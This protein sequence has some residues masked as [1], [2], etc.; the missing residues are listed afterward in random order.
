MNRIFFFIALASLFTTACEKQD[1]T[2]EQAVSSDLELV[3]SDST[4]QLTG[5]AKESSSPLMVNYPRWSDIYKY[6]V[7]EFVASPG[8]LP[9]PNEAMNSWQPGQPGQNKWVCVQSSYYDDAGTLWIL[10][11]AAPMLKTIQGDGAK[12][13]RMNKATRTVD[14]TYSFMG[15]VPDTAYVNDVRV[16]VQKQF[17][18]L[19]ESKGGGIIVV[20]LN[21]GQMRRWLSTHYSTK[22][23]PAYKYIIDGKELMKEG[24]PAKFNSD[25]IALTPDGAWLYYKPLTDDK[26]YRI[27]TEYLRDWNLSDADM[28]TKVEDLG[29]FAS[30]DGMIFDKN[31]NLYFGDPQNYRLLKIDPNLNMTTL[32]Q[33][34]RLIWPDSYAIADGYL[35]ISCSQIQKQPEYNEGVNKRTSP[36]TVYRMKL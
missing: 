11:P 1:L 25:G 14:R 8:I 16:D 24:K 35:Y 19:T 4:Y 12:L 2:Q 27:K 7:I 5:I 36:Y 23:D 13:V 15:I 21:S 9:Y 26:L 20:D 17:A 34:E 33:D 18:Y 10:D 3:F 6:A 32:I 30:T 31:G 29:H 22:S 28:G